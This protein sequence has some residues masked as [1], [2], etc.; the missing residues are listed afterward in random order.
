MMKPATITGSPMPSSTSAS[1]SPIP[2]AR[3][4][5]PNMPPAPVIRMTEHT[6]PSA[7]SKIVLT[8][9]IECSRNPSTIVATITVMSSATLVLPSSLRY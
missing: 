9:A 3:S 1:A 7:L 2:E 6:G 8:S 4:T 5:A